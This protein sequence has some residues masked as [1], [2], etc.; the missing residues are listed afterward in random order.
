MTKTEHT[1]EV[2]AKINAP[3]DVV[4]QHWTD[5]KHIVHWNNASPEWHTPRATNDLRVGGRFLS[6]MEAKEGSMGFDFEGTYDLV[7]KH[8][9]IAYHMVDDRK[10]KI[11][12]EADGAQTT[13]KEV[14]DLETEN[15]M[16]LQQQG[17]Q[18]ILNN[19]K[20]YVE[21]GIA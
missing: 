15:S 16:E 1:I 12:F 21:G 13:V 19:F 17:W 11:T 9:L 18:A 6:R 8:E 2:S 3:I 4:W 14:F 7:K 5:P 10:V 20:R